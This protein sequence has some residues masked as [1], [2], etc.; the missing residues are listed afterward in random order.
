LRGENV[1][2]IRTANWIGLLASARLA[3]PTEC[4]FR[5]PLRP[6]TLVAWPAKI[7][8]RVPNM[9]GEIL[10]LRHVW[11]AFL[12]TARIRAPATCPWAVDSRFGNW[13]REAVLVKMR[14]NGLNAAATKRDS[15][16]ACVPKVIDEDATI[17]VR[18]GER[19]GERLPRTSDVGSNRRIHGGS[20]T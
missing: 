8:M 20:E 16:A 1:A 5:A 15:L 2:A 12:G 13:P 19:L 6:V 7:E 11:K 14:T 10:D 18:F 4:K 3:M 9:M 17:D